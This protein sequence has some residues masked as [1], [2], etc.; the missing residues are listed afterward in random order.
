MNVKVGDYVKWTSSNKKNSYVYKVYEIRGKGFL[1][2]TLYGRIP[3]GWY[4]FSDQN[5]S[6][7]TAAEILECKLTNNIKI[8]RR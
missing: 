6:L 3:A 2:E 5:W 8:H 7:A 4:R 1:V